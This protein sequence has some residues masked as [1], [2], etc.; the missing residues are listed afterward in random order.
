[1]VLILIQIQKQFVSMTKNPIDILTESHPALA[2]IV[3]QIQ[4]GFELMRAS[5]AAGGKSL[6]CGNGGSAAD[7]EHWAGELLKGFEDKR[8]LPD[9]QR[10]GLPPECA[11]GLQWALPVI[12]LPSIIG[13]GTAW[14]NDA[15]PRLIYA[16]LVVALGK[17]GDVLVGLSTSGNAQN[18]C[19]AAQTARAR[20]LKVLAL[21]GESGGKLAQL[22][23]VAV[24]VPATNTARVQEMHLPV[25]HCICRMLE[26]TFAP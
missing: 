10:T 16:Q 26:Q 7:S 24:R 18:V 25:Y 15:D 4:A 6:I 9:S 5:F 8:P 2:A 22:A 12:P 11:E 1:M 13:Y 3:P 23:D 14:C 21:T 19:F 20:G 17:P